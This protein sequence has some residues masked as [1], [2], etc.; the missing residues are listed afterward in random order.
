[1]SRS[2][3]II[4]SQIAACLIMTVLLSVTSATGQDLVPVSD[5]TGGSSVFVFRKTTARK[6]STAAHATRTKAARLESARKVKK[7]TETIAKTHPQRTRS[8]VVAPDKVPVN[9]AKIP[10]EEASRIF[11]GVGEYYFNQNDIE[12]SIS[13]FRE[14]VKLDAKSQK[15][16]LGLSDVLAWKGNDLLIGD[17][18][19]SAKPYFLEAVKNNPKNAAAYYGLGEL[20]SDK[21]EANEAIANFEKA[22]ANNPALTE[23]YTPLGILYYQKGEI[24]KA[25]G[26]LTKAVANSP[27]SAET[28]V[29]LGMIRF[30][31]NR[32]DEAM[33]AYARAKTIDPGYADAY[34]ENAEVLMRLGRTKDALTDYDKAASL[35]NNY[36]EAWRGAGEANLELRNYVESIAD[37]KRAIQLRNDNAEVFATLADA[38]RLSGKNYEAESSYATARD[39]ML[40]NKDYSRDDVADLYSRIGYVIG[41]QCAQNMKQAMPCRWP[42]AIKALEKAVELGGGNAVDYANLGWAYYNSARID[43]YAKQETEGKAKLQ[44]ARIDLEKAVAANPPW[45]QGPMLNLGMTL[46]DLGDY[47]GAAEMLKRVVAKE[48]WPFALNELGIAYRKQNN[49]K[50]AINQFRRAIDKND[51]FAEAHYNL[52]ESEFR[53]GNIGNAKKEY[54]KLKKLRREDLAAQLMIISNG[55]V[56]R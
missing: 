47:A 42:A 25:D 4:K 11:A 18:P 39:I 9:I 41:A 24:A 35:R 23:I 45:V 16:M 3:N 27:D 17:D 12:K 31:Q 54:Q 2:T 53:N 22:L 55:A 21:N 6:F 44:Q 26:F 7:Q 5:I 10:K 40:R 36:F 43:F 34:F 51:D 46:T 8:T 29:F 20:N 37:L 15:A 1:M 32:N 49:Y 52:A 33:A 50:E 13:F 48:P 38:Y 30:S 28:Q 56:G 14:S 19:Q